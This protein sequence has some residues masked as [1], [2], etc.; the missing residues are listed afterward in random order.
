MF[1][2]KKQKNCKVYQI[3]LKTESNFIYLKVIVLVFK[4]LWQV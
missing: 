3:I 1:L 4:H 2:Y